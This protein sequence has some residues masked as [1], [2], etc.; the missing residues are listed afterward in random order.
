[1]LEKFDID[2]VVFKALRQE[3][4]VED[5]KQLNLFGS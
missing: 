2:Q 3:I 5:P 1:M 4:V